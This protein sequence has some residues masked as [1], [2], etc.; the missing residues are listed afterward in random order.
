MIAL[1][2][3]HYND[4]ALGQPVM[5]TLLNHSIMRRLQSYI[6]GSYNELILVS[7]KLFNVMS[8]FAAGQYRK[9]V[10]E[11]FP[12]EIKVGSYFAL[13]GFFAHSR[14]SPSPNS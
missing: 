2:S 13:D 1:L 10:L 11:N 5:K 9:S 12:W 8:N 7:L 4:Y 3:F 14:P 6:G